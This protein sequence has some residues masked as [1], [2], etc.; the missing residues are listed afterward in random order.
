MG[1]S[2]VATISVDEF[3]AEARP[4]LERAL[5]A[6]FGLRDGLDAAADAVEFAVVNWSRLRTMENPTG[7]LFTVGRTRATRAARRADRLTALVAEPITADSTVDVDLQ[8]ALMRLPWEQ[9]VAVMLVHAHGHTYASA[10]EIMDVP[11]T[12]ITN[13]VNRG[14]TKLRHEVGER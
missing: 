14:L 11:V 6:R 5:I 10:A 9:R 4:S 12:S 3:L 1:G 8:R 13:H 7:Y 2:G